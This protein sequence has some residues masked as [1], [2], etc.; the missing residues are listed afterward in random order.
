MALSNLDIDIILKRNKINYNGVF[1]KDNLP[2]DMREGGYICNMED[3]GGPQGGTHWI[4]F[5]Y[6]A[7]SSRFYFD[8]FGIRAPTD[9][10]KIIEP[11]YWADRDIQDIDSSSCG[12]FCIAT[13]CEFQNKEPILKT[14]FEYL[15][16]WTNNQKL[17]ERIL[18][19][20][21]KYKS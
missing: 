9:I 5:F 6:S 12:Y 17:N 10:V 18:H 20:K 4:C 3:F 2:D 1:S 11:Y 21:F 16:S 8:S 14:W 13:I 19:S 7:D 15:D